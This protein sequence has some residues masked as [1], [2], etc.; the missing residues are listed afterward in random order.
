MPT[1][2]PSPGELPPAEPG[3]VSHYYYDAPGNAAA[4]APLAV[5]PGTVTH[6][7]FYDGQGRSGPVRPSAD[8]PG[9]DEPFIVDG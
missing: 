9:P 8:G 1:N 2:L 5:A 6:V 7:Y 4:S 3:L